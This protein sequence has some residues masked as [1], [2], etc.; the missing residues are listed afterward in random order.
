MGKNKNQ[1]L[2]AGLMGEEITLKGIIVPDEHNGSYN[3]TSILFSTDQ[4]LIFT[5]EHN[6]KGDELFDHL[7]DCVRVKGFIRD[8]KKGTRTIRITDYEILERR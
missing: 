7:R 8:N 4:E 1:L 3:T 5:V 2:E 6:A